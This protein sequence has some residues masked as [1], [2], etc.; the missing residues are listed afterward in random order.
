MHLNVDTD[1]Q[2]FHGL[3]G[4]AIAGLLF[5]VALVAAITYAAR[6]PRLYPI[7]YG[8]LWFLLTQLPTSLY[9][10]SEVENDHR[11]FFSFPG[12]MLAVVWALHLGLEQ[13]AAARAGAHTRLPWV[14]RA[15][16]AASVL[17]LCGYAYGAHQRNRVWRDEG[18]LWAD[19]V[20]KSP[21]NGRGLMNYGLTR[22][23]AGDLPGALALFTRAL[24]YTPNYPTLEVN[25]GVVNGLLA[26]TG[27][28]D[29]AAAA[30]SHFG[31]AVA[32]APRDD[33]PHAY[34]GRWLLTHGRL[35]EAIAQ[36]ETAVALDGQR[37][38]QRDL[39]LQAYTRAGNASAARALAQ[40]TLSILPGDPTA[41]ATL[42]GTPLGGPSLA[43]P[44]ALVNLINA[45]L[46]SFR[47]GQFQ[48][49]IDE[50]Q[51]ALKVDPH[52]AE[53]WNNLGAGYGALHQ[54]DRGIAAERRALE[55]NP[56]LGIAANNLRW[57]QSQGGMAADGRT[58]DTQPRSAADFVNLSLRLNQAGRFAESIGAARQALALDPNSAEAW[59]NIAAGEEAM[60][61]WDGAID[62][63][64][65]ALAIRPEFGLARNNLAWSLGQK[66]AGRR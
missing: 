4:P 58:P 36:L 30:E 49:S 13:L 32:L 2:P 43:Q 66:A 24:Q 35:P 9:T 39:L 51:A 7:A 57:F 53:A 31:R 65:R 26:D 40:T 19:D 47:A 54:W 46:A 3:S 34:F 14:P 45:S 18:S 16:T 38:L 22:M 64:Q 6:R 25:L 42:T 63:A 17:A 55:L 11:M 33:L 29:R 1:L 5:L 56:A 12:L 20:T 23:N 21:H 44:A 15:A 60:G 48:Q 28:P 61:H 27:Q 8:L 52:S 62:A 50:A 37:A 59:N 10:L 41:V